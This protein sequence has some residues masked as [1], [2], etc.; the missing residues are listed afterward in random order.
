MA[1]DGSGWKRTDLGHQRCEGSR[2]GRRTRA[3]ARSRQEVS[4]RDD[5]GANTRARHEEGMGPQ[6]VRRM[7]WRESRASGCTRRKK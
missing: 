2:D 5:K 1:A 4:S 7:L 3:N 6:Q